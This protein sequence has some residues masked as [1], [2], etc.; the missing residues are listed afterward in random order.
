MIKLS[1]V[2]VKMEDE[3]KKS[4]GKT[5]SNMAMRTVLKLR[6]PFV[7]LMLSAS[8]LSGTLISLSIPV[9]SN[10]G[11]IIHFLLQLI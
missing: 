11:E 4:L 3:K 8:T 2:F 9:I 7:K 6:T 1:G 10:H 5:W